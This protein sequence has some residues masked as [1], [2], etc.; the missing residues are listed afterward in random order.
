MTDPLDLIKALLDVPFVDKWGDCRYCGAGSS[1]TGHPQQEC[2]YVRAAR[3]VREEEA[4]REA[5]VAA[6]RDSLSRPALCAVCGEGF[7][8]P[9]AM[10]VRLLDG[11]HVHPGRCASVECL[12]GVPGATPPTF[13]TPTE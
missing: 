11:R 5:E 4:R 3:W 10:G 1:D 13:R 9:N 7:S 2:P 6:L 12:R 8:F